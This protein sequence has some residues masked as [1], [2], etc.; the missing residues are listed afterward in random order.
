M[1]N[2][3]ILLGVG[4]LFSVLLTLIAYFMHDIFRD[5]RKL[6]VEMGDQ[7]TELRLIKVDLSIIRRLLGH[8]NGL[9]KSGSG[10]YS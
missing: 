3:W 5:F 6:Q 8:G 1:E 4:G 2:Q 9:L 10:N 7:K